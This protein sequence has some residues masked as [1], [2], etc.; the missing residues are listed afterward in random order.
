MSLAL[1]ARPKLRFAGRSFLAFVLE[2]SLP[3]K[4]WFAD[5]DELASQSSGFFANRPVIL[6]LGAVQPSKVETGW[7]MEALV[8]RAIRV[9]AVEG[10]APDWVPGLTPLGGGV[11]S[12]KVIDFP[13]PAAARR[14]EPAAKRQPAAS[15]VIDRPVRS[16]E[17][18]FHPDGDL[19]VIGAVSSGAEVVAGGSIHVHGAIRG[20]A[21]AGATGNADAR[22]FCRKFEAEL[23]AI[24]GSYLTAEKCAPELIGKAV[25]IRLNSDAIVMS[26]LG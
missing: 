10:V 22:I 4:D 17:A 15:R 16:G 8:A 26:A 11:E 1:A 7:I 24:N 12:A 5:L 21:I 6:N 9:I 25:Q 13:G 3:V 20:R 2:P 18:I 19:T 23:V 14:N